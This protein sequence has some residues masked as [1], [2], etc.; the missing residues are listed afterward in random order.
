MNKQEYALLSTK[1]P[2]GAPLVSVIIPAYGSASYIGA[3]LDS[4]LAQTMPD[5]EIIV[6]NDGSPDTSELETVLRP[7][8]PRIRYV[9]RDNGGPSA[10]RNLAILTARRKYLAFLD[11]D[12]M[13]LPHH[14]ENQTRLL[15]QN[16]SVG[17]VYANGVQIRNDQLIGIAFDKTPQSEPVNFDSLLREKATVNTSS[18]VVLRQAVVEAG[19]FDERFKR[20]EDFDLWLRVAHVGVGMM[21]TREVQVAHRLGDGLAASGD[22]MKRALIKVYEKTLATGNLTQEQSAIARRKIDEL[23]AAIQLERAKE[24]LLDGQFLDAIE[25]ISKAR[26]ILPRWKWYAANVGLRIFPRTLQCV[27]RPHVRRVKRRKNLRI[28]QSL[29]AAGFPNRSVTQVMPDRAKLQD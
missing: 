6:V 3:T 17:L 23:F 24:F 12:D 14:L 7:Y 21:F 18:T 27:Y 1:V 5:Y 29:Q 16:P 22:L 13:W 26:T 20:C 4:V 25:K 15:I 11:S 2:I 28:G 8:C 9:K 19:M 10:A